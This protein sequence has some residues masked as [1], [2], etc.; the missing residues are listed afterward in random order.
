M[1]VVSRGEIVDEV[2]DAIIDGAHEGAEVVARRVD[3]EPTG[4]VNERPNEGAAG[5][6][7]PGRRRGAAGPAAKRARR[8]DRTDRARRLSD[9]K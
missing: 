1:V 9:G 2:K 6:R 7:G 3:G 8:P 4:V 5:H